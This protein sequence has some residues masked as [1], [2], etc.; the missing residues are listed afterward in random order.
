MDNDKRAP[1]WYNKRKYH[2]GEILCQENIATSKNMKK[3][4]WS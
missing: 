4:Y 3:K 1:I 2:M